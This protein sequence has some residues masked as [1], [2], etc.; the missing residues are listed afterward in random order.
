[1]SGSDRQEHG[2]GRS[3]LRTALRTIFPDNKEK[4]REF[5]P[6][7]QLLRQ[8]K[9]SNMAGTFGFSVCLCENHRNQNR[10][11]TPEIQGTSPCYCPKLMTKSNRSPVFGQVHTKTAVEH[12]RNPG[13]MPEFKIRLKMDLVSYKS[14][15][16]LLSFASALL[17]P[18][19]LSMQRR[20][21]L[22]RRQK[23]SA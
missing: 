9:G 1:M 17:L 15:S 10:E 21:L 6:K 23:A 3:R 8:P 22:V 14:S 7:S 20:F 13:A 16:T 4:Y 18:I 2:G 11:L 12:V 5:K 19:V